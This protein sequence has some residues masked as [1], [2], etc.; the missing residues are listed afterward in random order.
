MD[1]FNFFNNVFSYGFT[2]VISLIVAIACYFLNKFFKDKLHPSVFVYL[3]FLL[4]ALLYVLYDGIFINSGFR[5]NE[6]TAV[7][8][9]T[10]G[11]LS[12]IILT[13]FNRI[14]NG[15]SVYTDVI[16]MIIEGVLINYLDG[17]ILYK[18]VRAVKKIVDATPKEQLFSKEDSIAS[19][20]KK[21]CSGIMAEDDCTLVAKAIINSIEKNKK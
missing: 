17:D 16:S 4:G 2:L 12:I 19:A 21:N 18:T 7:N 6:T 10:C 15:E 14:K 8:G 13:L 5:L 20:V 1:F 3:P 9:V 11:S